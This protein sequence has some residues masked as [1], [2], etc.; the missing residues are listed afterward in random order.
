MFG[1]V[2]T[3]HSLQG[4]VNGHFSEIVSLN[5]T[6]ERNRVVQLINKYIAD[7]DVILD[8]LNLHM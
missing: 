2:F 7:V 1:D 8:E 6:G 3:F 5:T 4:V